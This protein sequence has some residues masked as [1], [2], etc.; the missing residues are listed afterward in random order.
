MPNDD[1]FSLSVSRPSSSR[2]KPQR[3]ED[4]SAAPAPLPCRST[5]SPRASPRLRASKANRFNLW[6]A[7]LN[8]FDWRCA[9]AKYLYREMTMED[10]LAV[11]IHTLGC[12]REVHSESLDGLMDLL[13]G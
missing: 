9:A 6:R 2:H 11:Y 3:P 8:G 10:Y 4:G 7:V 5:P 12:Y 1:M 13:I